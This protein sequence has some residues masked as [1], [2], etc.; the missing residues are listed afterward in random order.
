MYRYYFSKK[1]YQASQVTIIITLLAF[2]KIDQRS[3]SYN[4]ND[5]NNND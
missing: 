2:W 3:F 1:K 5:N 4:N